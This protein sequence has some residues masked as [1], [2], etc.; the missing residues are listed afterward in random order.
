MPAHP[1]TII[2][3]AAICP[4]IFDII[5]KTVGRST[6]PHSASVSEQIYHSSNTS[7]GRDNSNHDARPLQ[8]A[9]FVPPPTVWLRQ[10]EE[11]M[12]LCPHQYKSLTII[13]LIPV[14][15][16][17]NGEQGVSAVKQQVLDNAS[18]KILKVEEKLSKGWGGQNAYHV[19]GYC[20]LLADGDRNISRASPPG[21]V[22]T[23]TKES[24]LAL[25]KLREEVDLEKKVEQNM[26]IQTL[27]EI[28]NYAS[29]QKIMPG[30]LLGVTR[31]KELY[32]VLEKANETLLY[33]SDAFE[34]FSNR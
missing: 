27:R 34:K 16:I 9:W 15:S 29:E 25:S 33:A 21:K 11:G 7:P 19:S 20:Y 1:S 12:Y 31:G 26:I 30:L 8:H 2:F 32:M 5:I 17:L 3:D 4:S 23:L 18:L 10:T 22:T 24:L 28:W 13:L 14:S 6:L